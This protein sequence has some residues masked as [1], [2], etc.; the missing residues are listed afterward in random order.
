MSPINLQKIL[1][2]LSTSHQ[3]ETLKKEFHQVTEGLKN[4]KVTQDA[5]AKFKQAEKKYLEILKTIN[6][7]QDQLDSEVA[8]TITV[9]KKTAASWEKTLN[10]YKKKVIT[11]KSEVKAKT[12][13]A[14]KSAGKAKPKTTKK[15]AKT[16][17]KATKKA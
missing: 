1:S 13:K 4:L 17:R 6:S 9:L 12:A 8:K 5:E 14:K 16:T 7:A 15:V 3:V 11:K 2:N 10:L